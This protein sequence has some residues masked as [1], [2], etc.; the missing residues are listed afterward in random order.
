MKHWRT[1]PLFILTLGVLLLPTSCEK[2]PTGLNPNN[3]DAGAEDLVQWIE[4][5]LIFSRA[6][7]FTN[8]EVS[9]MMAYMSVAYYEGF[10]PAIEDSRTLKGQLNELTGI[11]N[12]A[13]SSRYNWGIVAS[14]TVSEM[15]LHLF[16]DESS[17]IRAAIRSQQN[18]NLDEYFFYGS[19]NILIDNSVAFGE[20]LALSLINWA[21]NDGYDT[22]SN[23]GDTLDYGP[24]LWERTPPALLPPLEPCWGSMRPFTFSGDEIDMICL[25]GQSINYSEDTASA[26]YAQALALVDAQE[27]LTE[28]Q[29][30]DAIYWADRG[31]SY[32]APGHMLHV[33]KNLLEQN[34]VNGSEAVIAFT[35]MSLAC[36]DADITSWNRKYDEKMMRPITYIQEHIE[37]NYEGV[38]ESPAHPEYPCANAVTHFA[39]AQILASSFSGLTVEDKAQAIQGLGTRTYSDFNEMAA[40]AGSAQYYSGNHYL[41]T[42]EVAEFHG[43]CIAQRAADLVFID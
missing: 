23:C 4:N 14:T 32:T 3:V 11:P 18:T 21:E 2:N 19:S 22:Y 15:L 43:R 1:L 37:L 29:I 20:D 25:S 33:L 26:Y 36:A 13:N 12:P 35:R 38:I 7:E 10:R 8:L 31:N 40:E 41:N 16:K 9:R 34:E 39:A 17:S 28:S 24:G 42:V 30:N 27:N 6:A 5:A